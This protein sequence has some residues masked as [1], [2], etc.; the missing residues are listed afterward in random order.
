MIPGVPFENPVDHSGHL[1]I[2]VY[3]PISHRLIAFAFGDRRREGDEQPAVVECIIAVL[4]LRN[5]VC[6]NRWLVVETNW[7]GSS[8]LFSALI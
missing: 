4:N 5:L 3:D 2:T 8:P 7:N 6:S 1:F